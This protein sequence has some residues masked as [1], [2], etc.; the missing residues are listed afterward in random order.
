MDQNPNPEAA[1]NQLRAE[2]SLLRRATE[3]LTD[4][5]D[6]VIDYTPTLGA[7]QKHIAEFVAWAKKIN[8]Q[9]GMQLTPEEISREIDQSAVYLRQCD[10]DKLDEARKHFGY[11]MQELREL[12]RQPQQAEQ[13]DQELKYNRIAFLIA[14]MI[15]W[16]IVPGA[17]ARSL[18]VSWGV[19]EW[20]A[21]R[22]LGLSEWD[23]G[24][25]L[26]MTANPQQWQA[27]VDQ[28]K[29]IARM[30]AAVAPADSQIFQPVHAIH[31]PHRRKADG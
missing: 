25:R 27:I 12:I 1:F 22:M 14:G 5:R 21:A 8:A 2:V 7:I 11:R 20:I 6:N 23:A 16:S 10:H 30:T 26:M 28:G 3:R 15:V 4:E 31:K 24:Q 13:Q 29:T 18:P 19:P 9:P 17:I